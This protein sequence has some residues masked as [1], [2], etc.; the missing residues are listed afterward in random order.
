MPFPC[1]ED[2]FYALLR[3]EVDAKAPASRLKAYFEA[4]VFCRYVLGVA[5]LHKVVESRR[6]LGAA[7]SRALTCPRQ[8]PFTVEQ[9]KRFHEC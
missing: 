3:A 7:S 8:D 9:L 2:Q 6:C 4:L 1:S 5:E